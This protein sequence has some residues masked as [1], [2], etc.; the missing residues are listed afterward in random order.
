MARKVLK[1]VAR[2]DRT[3]AA[4]RKPKP[5]P[6]NEPTL[7]WV[8]SFFAAAWRASRSDCCRLSRSSKRL[9]QC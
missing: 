4:K 9:K 7:A 2:T 8:D 6:I 5:R 3:R 1:Y